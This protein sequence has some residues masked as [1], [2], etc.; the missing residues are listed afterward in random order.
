MIVPRAVPGVC[1]R[2]TCGTRCFV[3]AAVEGTINDGTYSQFSDPI[4][5]RLLLRELFHA[6]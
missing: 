2:M 5:H 3:N 4:V 1:Q 6:C